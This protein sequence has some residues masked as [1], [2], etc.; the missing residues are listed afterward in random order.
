MSLISVPRHV[1][2]DQPQRI[3][4]H[5]FCD[6]SEAAYGACIYIRSFSQSRQVVSRLLCAKSRV[7]P[8]KNLTLPRLELCGAVLL[9]QLGWTVQQALSVQFDHIQYWSDSTIVLSWIN[10]NSR[11]LQTFVANRVST[12]QQLISGVQWAHVR[13]KENPADLISRGTTPQNLK[14]L[15]LWWSGPDWLLEDCQ[16]WPAETY[17]K[18]SPI[19]ELKKQTVIAYCD[20]SS[21]EIFTRFSSLSRLKRVTAYC[22]RFKNNTLMKQTR[23]TGHLSI[24]ELN[25]AMLVLI[26]MVQAVEFATELSDLQE[27]RAVQGK[28]K[29]IALNPFI[30]KTKIIRVGGR[31]RHSDLDFSK[32]HPIVL[33]A[34][35]PLTEL[36][37]RDCHL[38]HMHVGPQG[39]LTHLRSMYWPL[40]GRRV[41]RL[42]LRK[43]VACFRVRP[44]SQTQLMGDLPKER[45]T[46]ARAFI[47]S[48]VDYAGPF[49]IKL[50]RNKTGKAY[51]CIFV[52]LTTKATHLEIVSD[53]TTTAFLNALKRF[54][55]R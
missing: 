26:R 35:H 36:I 23:K 20:S 13:S 39:L 49:S 50:S 4:L 53:L 32:Q 19:P 45:V 21:R 44:K 12:I 8:L 52:C 25:N 41:I 2:C 46:P 55:A 34:N 54:V 30:D 24:E 42:V 6:A 29:L 15:N 16:D 11:E 31:L 37:I 40:S 5:G 1:M 43:C 47:N 17:T 48:G 22:M 10:H 33:P 18:V 14:N 38:K 7:A 3:E 27:N 28:S 51:L 9:A